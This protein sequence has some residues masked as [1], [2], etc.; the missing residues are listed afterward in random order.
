M[1]I[2]SGIQIYHYLQ[3][4]KIPPPPKKIKI[5]IKSYGSA[6]GRLEKELTRYGISRINGNEAHLLDERLG[7]WAGPVLL[8]KIRVNGTGP[9]TQKIIGE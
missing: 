7:F 1:E 6:R 9:F 2:R 3:E 8:D 5:K 4:Q